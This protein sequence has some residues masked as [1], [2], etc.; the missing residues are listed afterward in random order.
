MATLIDFDWIPEAPDQFTADNQQRFRMAGDGDATY[1][2]QMLLESAQRQSWRLAPEH[3]GHT[4][5][6][7]GAEL[8]PV[9]KLIRNLTKRELWQDVGMT[10]CTAANGI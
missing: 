1:F 6:G 4:D 3:S 7:V 2:K 5:I 10:I 8:M 9:R